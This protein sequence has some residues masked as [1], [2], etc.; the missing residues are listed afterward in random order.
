MLFMFDISLRTVVVDVWL[1]PL[2]SSGTQ[3]VVVV[4]GEELVAG[5]ATEATTGGG[6]F[7]AFILIG[8]ALGECAAALIL[9]L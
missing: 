8:V 5:D 6:C 4:L 2:L 7:E 9:A 3:E 1:L